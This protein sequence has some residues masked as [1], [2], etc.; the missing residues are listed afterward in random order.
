MRLFFQRFFFFS[1]Q[2]LGKEKHYERKKE[3]IFLFLC[4]SKRVALLK[5]I[6]NC[7][8]SKQLP[9]CISGR[10]ITHLTSCLR[11]VC[12]YVQIKQGHRD[13]FSSFIINFTSFIN[14]SLQCPLGQQGLASEKNISTSYFFFFLRCEAINQKKSNSGHLQMNSRVEFFWDLMKRLA[15]LRGDQFCSKLE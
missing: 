10:D 1:L 15:H 11:F 12:T 2:S 7:S 6:S 5:C 9:R 3:G 4:F 14:H 8:S 13:L